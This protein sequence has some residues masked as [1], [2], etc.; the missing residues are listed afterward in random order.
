MH[1]FKTG[2]PGFEVGHANGVF[3]RHP[4]RKIARSVGKECEIFATALLLDIPDGF[5]PVKIGCGVSNVLILC[6]PLN[7]SEQDA[8]ARRRK[9]G[10]DP[11]DEGL[12]SRTAIRD[13][14]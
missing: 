10:C 7:A 12:K 5:E 13:L 4:E 2:A 9:A 11:R 14:L 1:S 6:Q 3:I 8:I